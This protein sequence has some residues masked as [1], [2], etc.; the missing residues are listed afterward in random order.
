MVK[1][2]ISISG[3]PDKKPK[4]NED[5][6]VDL[7]FK[8]P[9]FINKPDDSTIF[10]YCL[11]HVSKR[12]WDAVSSNYSDNCT[13]AIHGNFK[14]SKTKAGMPI[15]EIYCCTITIVPHTIKNKIIPQA[16]NNTNLKFFNWYK[17]EEVFYISP[18][19]IFLTDK[20]HLSTDSLSLHGALFTV[21]RTKNIDIPICVRP[22]ENNKYSLVMGLKQYIVA[23]VMNVTKVPV[24]I[25]EMTFKEL[26]QIRN[27]NSTNKRGD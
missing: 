22:L 6:S 19:N 20:I 7:I 9:M 21:N 2:N 11:A 1:A 18:D 10:S 23:K 25:R 17:P 13:Y 15:I 27:I 14:A 3:K 8:T 24:V 4:F 5:G 26:A 16:S 12:A